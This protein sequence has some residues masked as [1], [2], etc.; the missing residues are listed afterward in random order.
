MQH[1]AQCSTR[2]N[3]AQVSSGSIGQRKQYKSAQA[4]KVSESSTSWLNATQV[5]EGSTG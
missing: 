2:L 5:G 4:A 3:A 1:K